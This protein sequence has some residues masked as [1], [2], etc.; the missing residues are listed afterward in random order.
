[1]S[2]IGIKI[3]IEGTEKQIEEAIR[4]LGHVFVVHRAPQLYE[5]RSDPRIKFAYTRCYAYRDTDTLLDQ[6]VAANDSLIELQ[7]A[8][9]ERSQEI[10]RLKE[11]LGLI[12][13]PRP[14]DAILSPR[15]LNGSRQI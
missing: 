9:G 6:L 1:M 10:D 14:F 13:K 5:S 2:S 8:C 4:R 7:I 15:K 3:R 12:P 11:E